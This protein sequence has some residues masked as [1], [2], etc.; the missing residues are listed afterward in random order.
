MKY[1]AF[2]SY[3]TDPDYKLSRKLEAFLEGF[4]DQ[5]GRYDTNIKRLNIC[6][7]GTNF[8]LSNKGRDEETIQR[9]LE[10]YLKQSK[11]LI[12]LCSANASQSSYCL[13]EIKWFL[14]N[15]GADKILAAFTEGDDPP[16]D[17]ESYFCKDLL[18]N[19]IHKTVCYDL[20]EFKKES[21]NW[22]KVRD[23]NEEM[24]KLAAHLYGRSIN[25]IM[26]LWKRAELRQKTA[27]RINLLLR[28]GISVLLMLLVALGLQSRR[29]VKALDVSELKSSITGLANDAFKI[30][31]K[32]RRLLYDTLM[33]AYDMIP[34]ESELPILQREKTIIQNLI[35]DVRTNMA[36]MPLYV[37]T[38]PTLVRGEVLKIKTRGDKNA[39][40][41]FVLSKG[42]SSVIKY[43]L[44][45][46]TQSHEFIIEQVTP[47]MNPSKHAIE[48][49]EPA[50]DTLLFIYD[51][52]KNLKLVN[53]K[54]NV[55]DSIYMPDLVDFDFDK[56]VK[57]LYVASTLQWES[58]NL[59]K[60]NKLS[61]LRS[62]LKRSGSEAFDHTSRLKNYNDGGITFLYKNRLYI[63]DDQFL[64][65]PRPI[66]FHNEQNDNILYYKFD[67]YKDGDG[68]RRE[69]TSLA[70]SKGRIV[71]LYKES[72]DGRYYKDHTIDD[73][74]S[75][76]NSFD[77]N[78]LNEMIIGSSDKTATVWS[79]NLLDKR[80]IGHNA[81]ITD[82]SFV[83]NKLAITCDEENVI[84]L[85]NLEELAAAVF[86]IGTI[87]PI[88]SVKYMDVDKV[89]ISI[90]K[91]HMILSREIDS[92]YLT[93]VVTVE[94]ST[95]FEKSFG[96]RRIYEVMDTP[97][98]RQSTYIELGDTIVVGRN[99]GYLELYVPPSRQPVFS[100]KVHIKAITD[101]DCSN[102]GTYI[103]TGGK[104]NLVKV[105][106]KN[107][108]GYDEVETLSDHLDDIVDID[109]LGNQF[110]TVSHD[111][112]VLLYKITE[113]DKIERKLSIIKHNTFIN[114]AA[115]MNDHLIVS[116]DDEGVLKVWDIRSFEERWRPQ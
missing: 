85:W 57:R 89:G 83:D 16:T 13:H 107:G 74:L 82:V 19:N 22:K 59:D 98:V 12:V 108:T 14:E 52:K 39:F 69:R 17:I 92:F 62:R 100:K 18:E 43:T 60:K 66:R 116:G 54:S 1:N 63:I 32:N 3:S 49:F 50:G 47:I 10:D 33:H 56:S 34:T 2:I 8:K 99:T 112:S 55:L 44:S 58:F 5:A 111:R 77:F 11:Y 81:S 84:R 114:G 110:L 68:N 20:R 7:D 29:V 35:K 113:N 65:P 64:S 97:T 9:I 71:E 26:P 67:S 73:H 48:K 61:I 79:N 109:V 30:K 95:A 75:F 87:D 45:L 103:I 94:D 28:T 24:T 25:D 27:R 72:P 88:R 80:L 31:D 102:R 91:H 86:R 104:D 70:L 41:M 23:L 51:R 37:Q 38:L 21:K 78:G 36:T 15:R 76:I 53:F 106:K 101:V 90:G 105:W 115:F 40:T 4:S 96:D 6:R 42:D 46:Q 93:P